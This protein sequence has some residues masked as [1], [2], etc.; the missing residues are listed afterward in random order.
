M[1]KIRLLGLFL[2]M[3]I[4][5]I[6][7][8]QYKSD[9]TIPDT[10]KAVITDTKDLSVRYASGISADVLKNHLMVLASDSLEGRE[11]GT[12]GTMMAS[13]Y[14][15]EELSNMSVFAQ[16]RP[17]LNR[18]F[19]P[20][21][22]TFS[23]WLDTDLFVNGRRFRLVWEYLAYPDENENNYLIKDNE[24]I[25]LGYGIDDPKYS[26]YKKAKVKDKIIMIRMGEPVNPKT[27]NSYITGTAQKSDWSTDV[28]KKLKV[29]KEKGV[30]LVLVID[31][32]IKAS[33]ENNR[34]RL[35]FPS[36]KMGDFLNTPI[37]TANAAYISP[38]IA[39]LIINENARKV[40]KA[41]R[42]I[43]KGKPVKVELP[44]DFATNMTKEVKVIKD[45]NVIGFIEGKKHPNEYIIL[46]AHYDHL[47]KRGDEIFNGAD[48]NASG[49]G[50]LLEIANAFQRA[51]MEGNRPDRSVVFLWLTGEEKGLLGSKYYVEHPVFPLENTIANINTDMVGRIDKKYEGNPDYIYVIGSDRLSSDLHR[52]NE[53]MNQKYC[54]L[55]LDYTYNAEDDPNQYYYRSDHYSF[56][57]HG[58][59]AIF[60]FNGVHEDYHRATDE[61]DKINFDKMVNI[62]KLIFHTAWELAN[63]PERIKVDGE[64]K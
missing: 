64:V 52:I 13:E 43:S 33:I 51:V 58:I 60:F 18:Y 39:S 34:R 49:S 37:E 20:V 46:S 22:F 41:D 30:K 25:Y 4:T 17:G 42:K 15:A 45:R 8:G 53:E 57:K 11:T 27:G 10:T 56:A 7:F 62:G 48:D 24:I 38:E 47:G 9:I 1:Y 40:E 14:I 54:H 16:H 26:D 63:R 19:E 59:P 35:L 21:A 44:V 31:E 55:T 50:M 23:K 32:D 3:T 29:A 2:M 61:V 28:H 6:A 36:P 5:V 12:A